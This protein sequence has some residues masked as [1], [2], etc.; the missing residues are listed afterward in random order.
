MTKESRSCRS[1][2]LNNFLDDLRNLYRRAGRLG[3]G[4]V[5]I[6][7]DNDIKDD[8]FLEYLNNV[9]SSGEVSL[10]DVHLSFH[11]CSLQV[12]GLITREEM[13]ET[14]SELAVKM[15]K[16][17]PKRAMTNENL[18]N[19]YRERLRKNL[20]VVLSFSPDNRKFR[21]R[22]LKFPALISGCTIDWYLSVFA[23]CFDSRHR[24]VSTRFHRWPLDALVAV[25]SVYLNRLRYSCD[26]G[27]DQE[28]RHRP[29]G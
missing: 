15:K 1:Y 22:A 16:E 24:L 26:Y 18:Q 28:E 4:T 9:L 7:T 25:S 27:I 17:Y 10:S 14:L 3:Q 29:D 8:Q 21:E 20:H 2:T 12:S 11:R 13:D 19:Y 5:F 6:F 23:G